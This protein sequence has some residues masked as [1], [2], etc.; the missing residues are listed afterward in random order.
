[1][2]EG[3]VA[4]LLNK[5]L[6]KYI[7]D[8][9]S[10][11]LNVGIFNGTVQLTDLKLKAE[12]LYELELPIEVKAGCI[13]KVS[14]DIP[15]LS[16]SS[17]PVLIHVEDVLILAGPISDEPYDAEKERLL[18]RACK[19]RRLELL[20]EPLA[21]N[22]LDKPRGFFE[23]LIGTIVNNVQISVQNVHI[24]YEDT[25]SSPKYPFGCGVV[26]QSL[27]AIT[28]SSKWKPIQLDSSSKTIYKLVKL[29]SFS[30]YWSYCCSS[31]GLIRHQLPSSNWK[32]L[33]KKALQTF[34]IGNDEFDF[35]LK[36]ISAK[37]KIIF[38]KSLEAKIPKL[39]VDVLLQDV[40]LQLSRQ[41]YLEMILLGQSFTLM[42]IN[43]RYRKYRPNIPCKGN[44]KVWWKYAYDAVVGEYVRP[45]SWK[46]IK[47]HRQN[48]RQYKEMYIKRLQ[49]PND[50]EIR[51]DVQM[52][53]DKLNIA[54]VLM[55]REEAKL[56]LLRSEPNRAVPRKKDVGWWA[57][58]FGSSAADEAEEE[59][60]VIGE[61]ER[62]FWSRLT[63]EEKEKLYEAIEY[64]DASTEVPE[65][66]IAHKVNFTLA[67]CTL[68]LVGSTSGHE[69]LVATLSQFLTSLET[70]PGAQ[71][72]KVSAR[73]E[74]FVIEGASS[75]HDL[76]T[77][78]SVDKSAS[79]ISP[80]HV[81]A[82]DFEQNPLDIKANYGV[83]LYAEPIEVVYNEH[84]VS[85][86]LT[87]FSIPTVSA[88]DIRGLAAK[89]LNTIAEWSKT[90]LLHALT[91]RKTFF[92]NIEF[93][94]P[95]FVVHEHGSFQKS[96][97][98][99]VID[100]GK[101]SFKS[102][103]QSDSLHLEDAT[104]MEIE[105]KLYDRF[106][107][108]LSDIQVLFTDSGDEW[109]MARLLPESEM[110]LV[111]KIKA[112]ALFSNS[113]KPDYRH[114][115]RHKLNV[116]I[117][118]LK[119]NLSD[120]RLG[121]LVEFAHNF[122]L[123][124]LLTIGDA[125][126]GLSKER[127][128]EMVCEAFKADEDTKIEPSS[129]ELKLI[130][131]HVTQA[132]VAAASRPSRSSTQLSIAGSDQYLSASDYSDE[133]PED[134][135]RT[136]DVPGFDDNVSA[137]N[138]V[139]SLLRF[140][141]GEVALHLARSSDQAD[142]PYLMLRLDKLCADVA[143][144]EYGPA[145]QA[146]IS[147]VYLVDKLHIGPTGEYL[148][149][150]S[151]KAAEDM[152]SILYRKV[153]AS[154][155]EFKSDFYQVEHSAVID[156]SSVSVTFH[157]EA[158]LTLGRYLLYVY[159]KLNIKDMNYKDLIPE[160]A[161][162]QATG[163]FLGDQD[164][165]VPPGA[166]KLNVALRVHDV[167]VRLC[168]VDLEL[169][170][171]SV[172]GLE[173][174][175]IQKA[176]EKL[177]VRVDLTHLSVVDLLESTLYSKVLFIE[178]DKLFDLKYVRKAARA[179]SI[180]SM[181]DEKLK[182][183]DGSIRLHVGRVQLVLLRRFFVDVQKFLEPFVQLDTKSVMVKSAE[184]AVQ[185]QVADFAQ[186]SVMLQLSIDIHAPTILVPQ[187]SDSPN[188]IVLSLGDLNIENFFKEIS[189]GPK[190]D[191]V[192]NILVRL[193]SLHMTRA[194][195]LLDGSTQPQESILEPMK[196]N[197]DIKRALTLF[198]RN[199]MEYEVR[200]TMD[201]VK[202]NIGQK[203]LSTIFAI[204]KE[205]F[206]EKEVIETH[207]QV[208][209]PVSPP[210]VASPAPA[211]DTVKKLQTFLT[212]SVD[213]YKKTNVFFTMEG[214][215]VVLYTDAEDAQLSSPVR[216]PLH[217]LSRLELEEVT[218]NLDLF[219]DHSLEVKCSL[220]GL[221]LEDTRSD[222]TLVHTRVFCSSSGDAE[223]M[224]AGISVSS[225]NMIDITYR[226]TTSGDATVDVLIEETSLRVSVPYLLALLHFVYEALPPPS[227]D[228][229]GATEDPQ[230]STVPRRRLPSDNT[231][232]YHSVVSG[233]AAHSDDA[234]GVSLS[235]VLK[236]PEIVFFADPRDQESEVI[237]LKMDVMV[238]YCQNMGQQTMTASVIN[239]NA[240]SFYWGRRKDTT[241][242]VVKPFN[243]E[244][245]Q[246]YKPSS[247]EQKML[248]KSSDISVHLSPHVMSTV[249]SIVAELLSNLK[250]VTTPEDRLSRQD[251]ADLFELWSPKPV[252]P[253][254]FLE[255]PSEQATIR[256]TTYPSNTP[257]ESL[258]ISIPNV[259][260]LFEMGT[261]KKRVP[262]FF[263]KASLEADIHD[264]SR[265]MYLTT[266]VKLEASYYSEECST[267][268][269]LIEPV[270]DAENCYRPWELVIKMFR[271]RSYPILSTR[272]GCRSNLLMDAVD[273][274][275]GASTGSGGSASTS[276]DASEDETEMTVIR[277]HPPARARKALSHKS[278]ESSTLVAVDSDSEGDENVLQRIAHA[279]GHLFSDHSSGDEQS[280]N[281]AAA[282]AKSESEETEMADNEL[283]T[284]EDRPVF[285]EKGDTH[286][287]AQDNSCETTLS[288]YVLVDSR[289]MLNMNLTSTAVSIFF[290]L[291]NDMQKKHEAPSRQLAASQESLAIDNLLGPEALVSVLVKDENE[292]FVIAQQAWGQAP[293][294][295]PTAS[296]AP[297]TS[298]LDSARRQSSLDQRNDDVEAAS[299]PL[300]SVA[301]FEE[302]PL[303]DLYKE[304]TT[305]KIAVEVPG[306]EKFQ[307]WM[308][309]KAGSSLFA[310]HPMKNKMRYFFILDMK[311]GNGKKTITARSPLML[312]N[313]LPRPVQ[314]LCEKS[315]L[316]AVGVSAERYAKNPFHETHI[317]LATLSHGEVYHVP[318]FVAHHSRI[319]LQPTSVTSDCAGYEPSTD[320]LWSQD[321]VLC[322]KSA[323]FLSC[324]S[325]DPRE[326]C[327]FWIKVV[328]QESR[329]ARM[330]SLG[331]ML[332]PNCTLHIVPPILI[333]N[334][335]PYPVE[336]RITKL[337]QEIKL[338]EGDSA[339]VFSVSPNDTEEVSIEV[340]Y[341]LGC[342]WKGRAE[343]SA[344]LDEGKTISMQPQ[345]TLPERMHR[346]LSIAT[347]LAT[348]KSLELFL[349]S[350]YWV[351]NKT[352]LPLQIRGSSSDI[353]Y[354]CSASSEEL[355]LFRFKKRKHKKAKLRV[356]NSSWSSSF[357]LDT[358]GNNGV[359][360]CKDKER[361]KKYRFFLR[362]QMSNLSLS[363][364]ITITP[365][366]LVVNNTKHYFRFMEQNEAADLWF[367]IGPHEC[368][369]FWPDTDSMK[370]YLRHKDSSVTSQ[371]FHFG[372]S[373][374]TVLRM[375]NGSAVC[376]EVSGGITGPMK[377]L[378][379]S[380][381]NG[382]APVRVENL[383]EDLFLKIH[384]KC[385][386]QV[387]L[388]SPY[389]SV[390]YTWDDPTL[391]R[392]LMWNVYNRKKP[393]FIAHIQR[394]G[395][396]KEKVSFRSLRPAVTETKKTSKKSSVDQSSTDDDSESE[397]GPLPKKTRRDIVVVYWISFLDQNQRV[398]LFTQDERVWKHARKAV[399][400]ELS[401][402]ECFMSLHG[403]GV[404]LVN[405]ALV[406]AAY[407][408]LSGAPALWEVR[409]ND[410]W[411][412]LTLELAAWL[413]HRWTARS[414]TAELKD[415]VQVDFEKMQMSKPFLGSLQ[416]IYHPAL[417]LQYRQ[418]GH[419]S[420]VLASLH[421]IQLDNQL[422]DAV[423][424]TVLHHRP[425]TP[426]GLHSP[427][428]TV[429]PMLEAA[430]LLH[431][432]DRLNLN[433][434]KYLKLLLQEIH[435][436]VDKG[437]LLSTYDFFSVMLA[438]PD[439]KTKLKSDM[440]LIYA[441]LHP[442][443]SDLEIARTQ[444][445]VFEYV[446]LSPVKIHLSFSP[447]G[448]VHK[449]VPDQA[450]LSQDI[451]D[452][453]L[454]SV[455]ATLSEIKDVEL[456]M[457]FFEQKGRLVTPADLM[458]EVKSHYV[459]QLVQQC[460]VLVLGLDVL[461]NP[462]GLVKDFTKGLGDFFY[463]P[464]AA[465]IQAPDEFAEGLSRGAQ[466]LMGHVVGSS[467]GSIALITGS[468]GQVLAV[469]S[470]DEDYQNKRR[471]RMEQHSTSL[472][473]SLAVAAKG[474]VLGILL[475]VSGVVMNPVSG[476]QLEGL[477]GFFKG[478]GKGLMG[479]MTKPTGG[480]VDMFSI[481]FDGIRRAA[482][483]GKGVVVRQRLPRFINQNLGLK[484][485]SQYQATGYRLLLQLSKGHYSQTDT[486]WAHA[487][488]GRD[489]RANIAM[490]TDRH[491]FLLEKCR[492]WGG[493]AI[494]WSI[495][496][497]DVVSVP[498]I[499]GNSLI[500]RV[501]QD[502]SI[503]S[504]TGNERFLI[505]EDRDV[506]EW[507]KLKIETAL[508]VTLE[509]RPCSL[510]S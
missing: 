482:E 436:K 299:T 148:E 205:N 150:L 507:L 241:Y 277:R 191:Y 222:A 167:K 15:W 79:E 186:K 55:A 143:L 345:Q 102:D 195:I 408:S 238:D 154:C 24:R 120:R 355:L 243:L 132:P 398:L 342:S 481:A 283:S 108:C 465:S 377:I 91:H 115:P 368:L 61:R 82:L 413:E 13:G 506:L 212:T 22:E 94:S 365:F 421:R 432:S 298:G 117:S 504:F 251:S 116:S 313:H 335:L 99:L 123:P 73:T 130:K 401:Q 452:V 442:F 490:I 232:G 152:V 19:S 252:S 226:E 328:C 455:G 224:A 284:T 290:K 352:G 294:F 244:L 227:A 503:S 42:E 122:P 357:C 176:N 169:A 356:Y 258:E 485:F 69:V 366:F 46:A 301:V 297:T 139:N 467:A 295:S 322:N 384:Q 188:L 81:F 331:T 402:L 106:N 217:A 98:I 309:R 338:E 239:L 245:N 175:Y 153:K 491:V 215:H 58:W 30:V 126:D 11:N 39:L 260:V 6:G 63:P 40:A 119:L 330:A 416:R 203:D 155:P 435:I 219:S 426:R 373:Q 438:N 300:I 183:P 64:A 202:V 496:L 149:L 67:N 314:L 253:P 27:T 228:L 142:K 409:V 255:E 479:L 134:W 267:W 125:V 450:S 487:P 10:E 433:T 44:E 50:A 291:W 473:E 89:Q 349:Y 369:P 207:N 74:G 160:A 367:D 31:S 36:P 293:A 327:P 65:H 412:P 434:V 276:D 286:D 92:F 337:A 304:K 147:G 458:E 350:P 54:N 394:D 97:N 348:E 83:M 417:W 287:G 247:E 475:G 427:S 49:M 181:E 422:P 157:R 510:D 136:L 72:F 415:Y 230:G 273:A 500:I 282:E 497:E 28:T 405:G 275:D 372:Q 446:H 161:V 456:R 68:S 75:D 270:M 193:S 128:E 164:P 462:Y 476:A 211:D 396:G 508:L 382:D 250:E 395:F 171:I 182:G 118:S 311:I 279:F 317:R 249:A 400:G 388:L 60:E 41:Q 231:S 493:W 114:L 223:T 129:E 163:L 341:Y 403:V 480:V 312:E 213:V 263:V 135:G 390:L 225:P 274:L 201:L 168:D 235:L 466:S 351:I 113:V 440:K 444:R 107:V 375:D 259:S 237:V 407:L 441:P 131:K 8:L 220:Q 443:K 184:K 354:D 221:L 4:H 505:C 266:D 2:F 472:P 437:F 77:V 404:S 76:V 360:M 397:I 449:T 305:E 216:D 17:E 240:S 296:S 84:S 370:M 170:D 194:I 103:L 424:P 464:I 451:L 196:L 430:L 470:F 334:S 45:Y 389:Q 292:R 9:D 463:E 206:E 495:R 80:Q 110:H 48:Y 101:L 488:L 178:D 447:R 460:Y 269:P 34:S 484:P 254:R 387:T 329:D 386:G 88:S 380:Y 474:F 318:L 35:V 85:E 144:M 53:E 411:K 38:N 339:P 418:S 271:D 306:F 111:P 483:M 197:L 471:K 105:E 179:K 159:Q 319:Y 385:L 210:L 414:R 347:H 166:T 218:I 137:S 100:M 32:N 353:I 477:E 86:L 376:V 140:V 346:Q 278:R 321:I 33:M 43:Q 332:V 498:S 208:S 501:R 406:E 52:L 56:E 138:T 96:G 59:I 324:K 90:G 499:S 336:L 358:V 57:S 343:L 190:P 486:Y 25:V 457:A 509:E 320:G 268:E 454:N 29:E 285:L 192:D 310:L 323:K 189:A 177:I 333:H 363:K 425:A 419:Q 445:T 381:S 204:F 303:C 173:C 256:K 185:Q 325:K 78:L 478:I 172:S 362:I 23:N 70:R 281:E 361:N 199:V 18:A 494:Q 151:S 289:D 124:H 37:V 233:A 146:S 307:C 383:C 12:A 187:K 7:K 257:T 158:L 288:T 62:S 272:N 489:D 180:E 21:E 162:K 229:R 374:N 16:L 209:T 392:T 47:E 248:A 242:T 5:Y 20:E 93:K 453:F 391:E 1:M 66:Y 340:P 234:M 429:R 141:L 265:K 410:A 165:P 262:A 308:P 156:L 428:S 359:A 264:W 246:S 302:K 459:S 379:F 316:E 468:L 109:R 87:F 326:K 371:H 214:L 236:R 112:Q 502:E 14:V 420:L 315:S 439:E 364:I 198:N 145:F 461:G 492:F 133:E 344:S 127:L 431:H 399:D 26:L 174:D 469:L 261:G 104:K 200:G 95:Y 448:T 423:F 51:V 121:L 71:A 280:E 3:V 378:L 393:G